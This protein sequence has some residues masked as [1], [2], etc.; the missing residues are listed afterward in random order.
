ML[1]P[2]AIAALLIAASPTHAAEPPPP[3]PIPEY[4]MP[5]VASLIV[6]RTDVII[7]GT[8]VGIAPQAIYSGHGHCQW[9]AELTFTPSMVVKGKVAGDSLHAWTETMP[10]V[11]DYTG[12]GCAIAHLGHA[13]PLPPQGAKGLFRFFIETPWRG[14]MESAL[15]FESAHAHWLQPG[16]PVRLGEAGGVYQ[17][18]YEEFVAALVAAA[19]QQQLK[20]LAPET[21]FIA[22]VMLG[23]YDAREMLRSESGLL[24]IRFPVRIQDVLRGSISSPSAFIELVE[25]PD[26]RGNPDARMEAARQRHLGP[27]FYRL[28]SRRVLAMGSCSGNAITIDSGIFEVTDQDTVLLGVSGPIALSDLRTR[29]R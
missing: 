24:T 21:S 17:F 22:V 12:H 28:Q 15:V 20:P 6:E 18:D 19:K 10:S 4:S 25:P 11:F 2:F 26:I 5:Q 23:P 27:E 7:E 14:G 13:V 9:A 16:E 1:I 29:L 8:L 3:L